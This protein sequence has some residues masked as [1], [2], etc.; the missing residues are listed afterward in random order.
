MVFA[1]ASALVRAR[2]DERAART[3]QRADRDVCKLCKAQG[4]G[5]DDSEGGS[6]GQIASHEDARVCA[7]VDRDVNALHATLQM[8]RALC[9]VCANVRGHADCCNSTALSLSGPR[10]QGGRHDSVSSRPCTSRSVT[11][12]TRA[13]M[14]CLGISY[15]TT[16]S[17]LHNVIVKKTTTSENKYC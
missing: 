16:I 7:C 6:E 15:L 4:A 9:C 2:A 3:N 8:S 12:R 1:K 11:S 14:K 17:A 10:D 13:A 5:C